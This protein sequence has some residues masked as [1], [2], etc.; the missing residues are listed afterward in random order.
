MLRSHPSAKINYC[1]FEGHRRSPGDGFCRIQ[2]KKSPF[3][4]P[5]GRWEF[6]SGKAR[7]AT[8]AEGKKKVYT[9]GLRSRRLAS[10]PL[11]LIPESN[12]KV[13]IKEHGFDPR[14]ISSLAAVAGPPEDLRGP[15]LTGRAVSPCITCFNWVNSRSSSPPPRLHLPLPAI[16]FF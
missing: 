10:S 14:V 7:K 2:K 12:K 3:R 11:T 15:A 4:K 5:R 13:L 8:P 9:R 16:A 1:S 6:K